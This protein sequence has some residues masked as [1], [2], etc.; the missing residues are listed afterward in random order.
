MLEVEGNC[1]DVRNLPCSAAF[2]EFA[3]SSNATRLASQDNCFVRKCMASDAIQIRLIWLE[4]GHMLEPK[5]KFL[6]T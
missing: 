3:P 5:T 2:T 1:R 6:N 4:C